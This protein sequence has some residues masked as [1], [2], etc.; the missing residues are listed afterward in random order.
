MAHPDDCVANALDDLRS[1][2]V[3]VY[4][5]E[6]RECRLTAKED[7]P[8]GFK[9]AIAPIPKGGDIIKYGEAIGKAS[10][11]IMIGDCVHVHNVE[12]KRGRGDQQGV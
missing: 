8:F 4:C 11:D 3:F 12:G 2:D 10:C 5:N 9:V 7:I 1:G 6:N